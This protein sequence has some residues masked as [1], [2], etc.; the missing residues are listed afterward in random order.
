M[1]VFPSYL[2]VRLVGLL[3]GSTHQVTVVGDDAQSIYA[4]R[5]AQPGG[6]TVSGLGKSVQL[7]NLGTGESTATADPTLCTHELGC[8]T[9]AGVFG[10]FEA[11]CRNAGIRLAKHQ[12]ELNYRSTPPIVAVR[13]E[14]SSGS[15]GGW[16]LLPG[17]Q[18]TKPSASPVL[19]WAPPAAAVFCQVGLAVLKPA[20]DNGSVMRKPL[21]AVKA[22]GQP[23]RLLCVEDDAKEAV[24]IAEVSNAGANE[25]WWP[26][27]TGCQL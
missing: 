18:R 11:A 1:W 25:W 27:Q 3:Q 5:G 26:P 6:W 2:Q 13:P 7:H 4:F 10:V 23:V 14:G 19:S 8:Q 16:C 9:R 20:M 24:L 21:T 15:G 17:C 22:A 12:L